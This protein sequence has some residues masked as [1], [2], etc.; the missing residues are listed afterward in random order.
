MTGLRARATWG[1]RLVAGVA[2]IGV[3]YAVVLGALVLFRPSGPL[4]APSEAVVYAVGNLG[5]ANPAATGVAQL[6]NQHQFAALLAVGNLAPPDGSTTAY[7]GTYRP[8]FGVFDDRVRPAPGPIE[9]RTPRATGYQA[10][11]SKNAPGYRGASFY[12]F[13]VAGWRIFSLD[14]QAPATPDSPMYLWLRDALAQTSERCIAAYWHDNGD[15]GISASA[16]DSPM[17][18]LWGLLAAYHADI[19][20]TASADDYRRMP[21]ED[22]IT[23]FVV[24]TGG[25]L[26]AASP[27]PT[28]TAGTAGASA[29]GQGAG[30]LELDVRGGSAGF[31]FRTTDDR[32]VDSGRID[33]HGRTPAPSGRPAK[34]TLLHAVPGKGG[35]TLTWA[36]GTGGTSAVG[37]LVLRGEERLAFT[38]TPTYVDKTL[39]AGASVLY[40]V[41]AIDAGGSVSLESDTAHSGGSHPGFTDFA[42]ATVNANP[43]SPTA[44]KPQ[45]KLWVWDG[46][47]W[48]ILW[49]HDPANKNHNAFYIERFDLSSQAWTNT[50]VEVDDRDR[51][52][53]D[54]LWDPASLNLYVASTIDSG[55]AKLFR[56]SWE[57]GRYVAD[58]GFPIHLTDDGSE[59]ITIGKDSTGR[60]WAT[61][62][63]R[64][65]GTGACVD[66]LPCVVKVLHSLG[67]EWD[68]SKPAT[69]PVPS[70]TVKPD[71]IST[72][73]AFG[74][75]DIGVAWSNQLLGGFFFSIHRD[76]TP[77]TQWTTESIEIAPRGSDDHMNLKTDSQGRV[78]LIGK[79]SLNDPANASPKDPLMVLWVR[80]P[81]GAWRHSTVWTV[82]DNTTRP[83]IVIDEAAGRV[84]AITAAHA[85]GGAIYVKSAAISDLVFPSGLGSALM[86]VGDINNPT[87]TKQTVRLSDGILILAGD[88]SSHTYWHA[89]ITSQDIAAP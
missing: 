66:G 62:T 15:G 39:P 46:S 49:D 75:K 58:Q 76:G 56:Y 71:D 87:T 24:G 34:P 14:S 7:Q 52:H 36:P 2:T 77:D 67:V 88:T 43:A 28:A 61:M 13:S 33:C 38:T 57:G 68:W 82:A 12:D 73:V 72:L 42:W 4:V 60:L 70:A 55:G 6:L 22:G 9:Y 53:A 65:D 86:A 18:Y 40:T 83:Q 64:P 27:S 32:S 11:F 10:Y 69:L 85:S 81:S 41:R 1:W 5:G 54:V 74:G 84:Y 63:Q 35:V 30:A 17:R 25:A 21:V 79:T 16:S 8:V 26:G 59:S 19:V 51:S 37:Y 31:T 44:D 45:S 29:Q 89:V 20:L 50:G 23:M 80:D 48:G 78:Y 3:V 47:W